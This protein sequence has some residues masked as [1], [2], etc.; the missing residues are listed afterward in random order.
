MLGT[1]LPLHIAACVKRHEQGESGSGEGTLIS[2]ELYGPHV[3][4]SPAML[5]SSNSEPGSGE[6]GPGGM[7]AETFDRCWA[8]MSAAA[9][10]TDLNLW[11]EYEWWRVKI[12]A[13]EPSLRLFVLV[14]GLSEYGE[15]GSTAPDSRLDGYEFEE[16]DARRKNL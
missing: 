2:V 8:A 11:R 6:S 15:A 16:W 9:D 4:V 1:D 13:A 3:S 14:D 5:R 10:G 12:L 7:D